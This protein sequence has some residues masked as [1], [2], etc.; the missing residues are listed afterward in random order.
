MIK[1]SVSA[2][3]LMFS[4]VPIFLVD[5]LNMNK[6]L[7][8]T[9][10][11]IFFLSFAETKAQDASPSPTPAPTIQPEKSADAKE[12]TPD[13]LKAVD[14]KQNVQPENLKDVPKIA[15]NYQSE[16]RGLPDL[17]LVGVDMMQQKALSL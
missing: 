5:K 13:E 3:Q 2:V 6:H 11:F 8:L 10:L 7:F 1:K 12:K 17:G 16:D 9:F 15:P 4:R 14:D